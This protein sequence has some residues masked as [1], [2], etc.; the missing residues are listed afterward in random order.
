MFTTTFKTLNHPLGAEG[1][2]S[3]RYLSGMSYSIVSGP[4]FITYG[5]EITVHPAVCAPGSLHVPLS[6]VFTTETPFY[7]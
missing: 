5:K 7:R 6:S 1:A 3:V 2:I 4:W